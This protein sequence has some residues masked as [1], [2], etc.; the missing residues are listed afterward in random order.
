MDRTPQVRPQAAV[1]QRPPA[2]VP[3][4]IPG[5]PTHGGRYIEYI[6]K[7]L[8]TQSSHTLEVT[9]KYKAPII[10]IGKGSFGLVC[11]CLNS[12]TNEKVAIK[13]ILVSDN[14]IG[15]KRTL[16]EIKILR[17]LNHENVVAIRDIIPPPRRERFNDVYIAFEFMDTDLRKT[18]RTNQPLTEEHCQ[19]LLYQIL[20]G[21]KY[22]HSANV[23]HR[24]LKPSNLL[25]NKKWDLK[26]C[27]F[28]LAR[29]ASGTDF[30][31]ENVGTRQY[32]S[33]ELLLKS[34]SY[35]TAI[36]VWSVGC[37]FMVLMGQE[38]LFPG[39]DITDQLESVLEM[40]GMPTEN[41]LGWL[42]ENQRARIRK[43]PHYARQSFTEKLPDVNP[44]AIDLVEKMLTF[45][46]RQRITVE[47]ALAHPYL[48]TVRDI[49]N[50]PDC[51]EPCSYDIEQ[52]ELTMEEMKD[53]I[54]EEALAL[55]PQ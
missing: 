37:I 43:L 22:I 31:T 4:Q 15:V 26:I 25:V 41:D 55:N 9:S 33:P 19:N 52:N 14:K 46:P 3:P 23:L 39:K 18:I 35:S 10:H 12:E 54:Y 42:N 16:R 44:K 34:A 24:D 30:M 29:V 48:E 20:C 45:D 11:S 50:E 51:L 8:K 49:N 5:T 7:D 36:D 6:V 1:A 38:N 53:L 27:D 13:K 28:G 32:R 21:L 47:D 40:I 2:V 17:H